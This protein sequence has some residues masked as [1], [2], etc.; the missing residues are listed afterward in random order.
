MVKKG[1]V[2]LDLDETLISAQPVKPEDEGD[3]V[4]PIDPKKAKKFKFHDMDGYY[5]VFE[6]PGL[7]GFLDYLFDNFNVSIWTAASKDYALFVVDKIILAKPS[8]KLSHI[9]YSYHG[10]ISK[11]KNAGPKG[12]KLLWE[13]YDIPTFSPKSTFIIDDLD[14]VS[15]GQEGHCISAKSFV[16]QDKDS[17][18]DNFL[19]SLQNEL[20]A[21]KQ[22]S[23]SDKDITP[24]VKD[25]NKKLTQK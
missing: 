18:K 22:A 7:Q 17:D 3:K 14:K 4:D 1:H 10:R 9:F 25:I 21:I 5:M 6:R 16:F 20:K 15:E 8:R 23:D 12:L 24:L 11:K 13:L 2:I 19:S